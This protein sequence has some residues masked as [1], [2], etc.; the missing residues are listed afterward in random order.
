M[1]TEI[2]TSAFPASLVQKATFVALLALFLAWLWPGVSAFAA[3]KPVRHVQ[4][5]VSERETSIASDE[6]FQDVVVIG[7]NATVG[8]RVKEIL[9]VVSGDLHLQSSAN[10]GT[11][12]DLGGSVQRDRGARVHALYSISLHSPFWGGALFGG[13][14]ALLAWAG[15]LAV[16]VALVVLSLLITFALRK[17]L[18]RA[19]AEVERSVRRVGLVGVFTTLGLL[20]VAAVLT[21]TVVGVPIAGLL[22]VLY[23]VTGVVGFA[24]LSQW[25][26][27]LA[28]S[29]TP[30]DRPPWLRSLVGSIL[31]LA[32]T[33]IPYVGLLLFL[34]LWFAGVGA[35]TAWLWTIR[36][37]RR[38]SHPLER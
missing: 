22:L 25:L 27:K 35:V 33:N 20:A 21:V 11:V 30:I 17:Q 14:L 34:L 2:S 7:H 9:V 32:F 1:K 24:I 37:S 26:G 5:V 6:T 4:T 10:V 8:G 38:A 15:M 19:L 18:H 23:V 16:D 36:K 29:H 31:A 12:I 3:T 28:L 13:T